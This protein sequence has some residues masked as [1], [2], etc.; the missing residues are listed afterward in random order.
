ML[1]INQDTRIVDI[2]RLDYTIEE[3]Q[4]FLYSS[5]FRKNNLKNK[6]IKDNKQ[7]WKIYYSESIDYEGRIKKSYLHYYHKS[8]NSE[9]TREEDN[10]VFEGYLRYL[11]YYNYRSAVGINFVD[12]DGINHRM[13]LGEVE[14]FYEA[15][16]QNKASILSYN[17]HTYFHGI[18]TYFKKGANFSIGLFK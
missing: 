5:Y 12:G 15:V 7:N 8:L 18:F 2:E 13:T 17:G 10:F 6:F 4:E 9:V 14:N 1:E 11:D 3:I 16:S